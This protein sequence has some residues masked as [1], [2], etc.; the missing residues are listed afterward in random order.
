MELLKLRRRLS[1]AHRGHK[2]LRDKLDELMRRFLALIEENKSLRQEVEEKLKEIFFRFLMA[3]LSL[4]KE[5]F[6]QALV[7]PRKELEITPEF[8]TLLNI[9]FP[10]F[11]LGEIPEPFNYGLSRNSTQLDVALTDLKETLPN[12]IKLAQVEREV[13]LVS[14]EIQKTR[15]RV[16]ALEYRFIPSLEETIDFIT[17]RLSELER[18]S[19]TRL[20]RIK[21]RI[22]TY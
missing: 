8:K 16:N 2:L 12:L 15:R 5:E 10:R 3:R 17:F 20:M 4:P 21:E 18:E 11:R 6:T 14:E 9:R 7:F 22:Q 19:L 13:A 1:L